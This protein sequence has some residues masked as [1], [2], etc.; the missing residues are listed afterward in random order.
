MK[1]AE[2]RKA[3]QYMPEEEIIRVYCFHDEMKDTRTGEDEGGHIA[4]MNIL[5]AEM[6]RRKNPRHHNKVLDMATMKKPAWWEK[7]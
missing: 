1:K 7:V 2:L 5:D 4:K 6:E 3:A